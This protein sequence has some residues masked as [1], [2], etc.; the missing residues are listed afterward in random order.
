MSWRVFLSVEYSNMNEWRQIND[1]ADQVDAK[2]SG[3][4]SGFGARDIDW[5]VPTEKEARSLA[6]KLASAFRKAGFA[7]IVDVDVEEE[8]D[9]N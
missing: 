3:A 6:D 5:D 1:I 4:G 7:P 8:E 9:E 2:S